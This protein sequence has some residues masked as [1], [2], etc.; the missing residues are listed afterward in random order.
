[1]TTFSVPWKNTD[2]ATGW[3]SSCAATTRRARSPW[4]CPSPSNGGPS[5]PCQRTQSQR[6]PITPEEQYWDRRRGRFP[7]DDARLWFERMHEHG[8][9]TP[10]W[11]GAYG[12]GGLLPQEAR[13]LKQ[14]MQRIGARSPLYSQGIWILGPAPQYRRT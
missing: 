8:W 14:E 6:R 10:E 13:I 4:S 11:P 12:G 1:M 9:I 2:P 3:L 5:R 7:S